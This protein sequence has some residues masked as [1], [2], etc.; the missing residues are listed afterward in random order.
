MNPTPDA[1]IDRW[2]DEEW[3]TVSLESCDGRLLLWHHGEMTSVISL[4]DAHVAIMRRK[5]GA[6]VEQ[7]DKSDDRGLERRLD[8]AMVNLGRSVETASDE[9]EAV[10][11]STDSELAA[12]WIAREEG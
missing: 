8:E 9:A 10:R 6:R 4:P 1:V 3:G 11:L 5:M 7:S 12:W 2:H